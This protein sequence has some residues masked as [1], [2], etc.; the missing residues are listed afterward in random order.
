[1]A[2]EKD[3]GYIRWRCKSCGKRLKVKKEYEGGNVIQCPRCRATTNVPLANIESIAATTDMPETG[4]PGRL[5]I[6][7]DKLR[8]SLTG[9]DRSGGPGTEGST[10]SVRTVGWDP[11]AAYGRLEALDQL[12]YAVQKIDASAIGELQRLYRNT[13]MDPEERLQRT[14]E[15]A[16]ARLREVKDKVEE[17][18]QA[19]RIEADRLDGRSERLTPPQ[20]MRLRKVNASI[21]AMRRYGR[22]FLGVKP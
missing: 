9:G 10:A 8:E 20:R 18:I 13:E 12:V 2:A 3:D 16:R 4:M 21:E 6:D 22:Y 19:L 14:K 11:E 15:I 1:M 17:R 5:H 7:P